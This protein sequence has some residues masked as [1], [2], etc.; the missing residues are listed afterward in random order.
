MKSNAVDSVAGSSMQLVPRN[1]RQ[2]VLTVRLA[3]GTRR[4]AAVGQ[5]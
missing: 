1:T 2:A 3:G 4:C 5:T